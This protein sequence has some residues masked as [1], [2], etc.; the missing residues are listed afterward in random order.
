MRN[1]GTMGSRPTQ[2]PRRAKMQVVAL[3]LALTAGL[4][5]LSG[6]AGSANAQVPVT[7]APAVPATPTPP[8]AT[9]PPL[10]AT[11]VPV[12]PPA[13]ATPPAVTLTQPPAPVATTAA[14][15]PTAT[16]PASAVPPTPAPTTAPRA[17]GV[18]LELAYGLIGGGTATLAAGLA[19]LRRGPRRR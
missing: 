10:P 2:P 15:P 18:P 3:W 8:P 13:P 19:M 9:P 11:S 5:A 17:G 4:W 12:A 1:T 7:P 14:S 16:R 6:P